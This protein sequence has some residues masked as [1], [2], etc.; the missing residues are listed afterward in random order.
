[1]PQKDHVIAENEG[2][3]MALAAGHHLATG[4]VPCVYLQN[5]GLEN[6]AKPLL[7]LS[8]PKVHSIPA[9][10]LIGWRGEPGKTDE[11]QRIMQGSSTPG[12]LKEMSVPCEILPDYVEGAFD[13]LNK[14]Y[15]HMQEEKGPYALLVREETFFKHA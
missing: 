12:L 4:K 2:S 7:S 5:S 8:S 11:P 10:L 9:L 6:T 13:V 15:K 14:A 1:V 3:A